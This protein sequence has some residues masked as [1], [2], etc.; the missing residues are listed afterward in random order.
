MAGSQRRGD[1]SS[2][3]IPPL[4][5]T[6][7]EVI[8]LYREGNEDTSPERLVKLVE[9]DA[10]VSSYVLKVV[11]SAYFGLQRDVSQIDRAITLLGFEPVCNVVLSVGLRE[12]FGKLEDARVRT[13]YE[14]VMKTSL[15]TAAFA[16]ELA[17]TL[18]PR[19]PD[20]AFAAGLVHQIGR[21]VL[22]FSKPA[23]YSEAWDYYNMDGTLVPEAPLPAEERQQLG[24]DYVTIGERVSREWNFP[25]L[26][27]A[28]VVHHRQPEQE[29]GSMSK[30]LTFMVAS[31]RQ[32]AEALFGRDAAPS[33]RFFGMSAPLAA[34]ARQYG[35]PPVDLI[36]ILAEQKDGVR[37]YA[38]SIIGDVS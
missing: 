26:I 9:R 11:N 15:A 10:A 14:Y 29:K 16:R 28:A 36:K 38:E 32:A 34:L 18:E 31:A 17:A 22:L 7:A 33:S 2:I 5:T 21:L 37:S 1:A 6:F 30:P 13:V 23:A 24:A 8:Q 19:F 27:L 20:T 25:P 12:T 3:K 4:S 35:R